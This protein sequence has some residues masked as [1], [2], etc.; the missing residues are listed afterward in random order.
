MSILRV[1]GARRGKVIHVHGYKNFQVPTVKRKKRKKKSLSLKPIDLFYKKLI[2]IGREIRIMDREGAIQE[3][4]KMHY[5]ISDVNI[6]KVLDAYELTI[7]REKNIEKRNRLIQKNLSNNL[8]R[9]KTHKSVREQILKRESIITPSKTGK[10]I[11]E[12]K[13]KSISSEKQYYNVLISLGR[14]SMSRS[15]RKYSLQKLMNTRFDLPIDTLEKILD[16]YQNTLNGA[17]KRENI[18]PLIQKYLLYYLEYFGVPGNIQNKI[19]EYEP[20]FKNKSIQS[21]K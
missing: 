11:I 15:N 19:C 14:T 13:K 10:T 8:I 2:S 12:T 6:H 3:L 21:Q 4:K 18:Y 16:A 7:G 9:F 5:T 20:A 17:T 1:S